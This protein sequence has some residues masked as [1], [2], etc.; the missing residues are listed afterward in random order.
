M[1]LAAARERALEFAERLDA[2]GPITVT[3]FFSGAGLVRNGVQFAFVIRGVLYLR[4]DDLSRPDFE[5][6][7]SAPFT[8]AGQA[9]TV[10]VA[11]YYELPD[12]IADDPDELSR[13]AL[14]ACHTAVIAQERKRP[15]GYAGTV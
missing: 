3:R 6:L 11:S 15:K 7:G 12:E 14:R 9:K 1:S 5:A 8:Y 2:I 10:K 13:W 4:V